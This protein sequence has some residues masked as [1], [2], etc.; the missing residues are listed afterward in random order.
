MVVYGLEMSAGSLPAG[1]HAAG[2]SPQARGAIRLAAVPPPLWAAV[3]G[4]GE[5]RCHGAR[6]GLEE[7]L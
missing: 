2:T 7:A 3:R 5:T 4:G 1:A 6:A